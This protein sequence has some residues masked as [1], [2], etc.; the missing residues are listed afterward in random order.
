MTQANGQCSLTHI[1]YHLS[2]I[3]LVPFDVDITRMAPSV[4]P[5]PKNIS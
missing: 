4:H 2:L 5:S 1:E 3:N